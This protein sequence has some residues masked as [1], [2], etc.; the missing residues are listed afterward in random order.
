[1]ATFISHSPAETEQ[2]GEQVASR[3]ERGWVLGLIGDL[4][5]GKTQFVKGFARGLGVSEKVL[6]PSFAIVHV[7]TTGRLPLF[8]LDFYRLDTNEQIIA[9]GLEEYFA[10][11]GIAL[12]EWWDRWKG[13]GPARLRT[14]NFQ[15]V[16]EWE[17][18]VTYDDACA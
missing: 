17:R 4:G 5:A 3:A 8:H 15:M 10:P 7:Y 1:M 18:H 16:N 11:D 12:I 14:F 6:S 2:F 9:V 13:P